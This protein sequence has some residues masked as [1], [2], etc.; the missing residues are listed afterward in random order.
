MKGTES[1]IAKVTRDAGIFSIFSF[2]LG[3]LAIPAVAQMAV[4]SDPNATQWAPMRLGE[5]LLRDPIWV[6][7]DWSAYDE[8]S[9]NIPLTE[10]LAMRELA[11]IARLQKFGVHF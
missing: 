10:E 5:P 3:L 6:Y 1:A 9:D 2:F 8:L 11:Q 7:N 4:S